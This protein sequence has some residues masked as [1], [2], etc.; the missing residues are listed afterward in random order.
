MRA[1][2]DKLTTEAKIARA[3]VIQTVREGFFL[4]SSLMSSFRQ[5]MSLFGQQMDPFFSAL[6]GMVLS[7]TSMLISSATVLTATV[8]GAPV[9]AIIF[10]LAISFNI[11]TL[12][13]L[14]ADKEATDGIITSM[15]Q[16]IASG[17]K[18]AR[19]APGGLGGF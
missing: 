4:L 2:L 19:P 10:G 3:L 1:A 14:I 15:M 11:L 13:K 6:I 5:A 8:L 12:G 17:T 16:A 7:T 9:G 18:S